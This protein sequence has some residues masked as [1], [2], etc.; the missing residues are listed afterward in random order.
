MAKST[1]DVVSAAE[2]NLTNFFHGVRAIRSGAL[3]ITAG[4]DRQIQMDGTDD[5]DTNAYH[6][7]GG[8]NPER[9]TVPAGLAGYYLIR[10]CVS[11]AAGA[12]SHEAYI[13]YNGAHTN[14]YAG[15]LGQAGQNGY[16]HLS[17][18]LLLAEGDYV[19]LQAAT[20]V[21]RAVVTDGS[22]FIEMHLIAPAG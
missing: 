7:P 1:G 4:G 17:L 9:L 15:H 11:W 13:K 14:A 5:I 10:G 8:A 6:D 19:E 16:L 18:I 21:N 3:T 2:W 12:E 20:S 22:T